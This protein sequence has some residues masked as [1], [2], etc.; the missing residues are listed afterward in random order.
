M[1][2]TYATSPLGTPFF[3]GSGGWGMCGSPVQSTME[4]PRFLEPWQVELCVY[5]ERME[6]AGQGEVTHQPACLPASQHRTNHLNPRVCAPRGAWW[7]KSPPP[8]FLCLD[9]CAVQVVSCDLRPHLWA[10]WHLGV[11]PLCEGSPGSFRL[12]EGRRLGSCCLGPHPKAEPGLGRGKGAGAL[13]LLLLL[14]LPVSTISA[15]VFSHGQPHLPHTHR[16]REKPSLG[17]F[18]FFLG[19]FIDCQ[20]KPEN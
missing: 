15:S 3:L 17:L 11:L 6:G 9:T 14:F 8:F 2:S 1:T 20:G 7:L 4:M 13:L 16:F 12:Q 5:E 19:S 18:F 10:S